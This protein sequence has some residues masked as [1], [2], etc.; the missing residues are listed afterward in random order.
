MTNKLNLTPEQ[1]EARRLLA[2]QMFRQGRSPRAVA[3]A[4]EVARSSAYRWKTAFEKGGFEALKAKKHPGAK[5]R[6]NARQKKRLV[7]ILVDG[8]IKAGYSNDLWTCPRVGQVI[9]RN[10]HVQYHPGHVWHL[11]RNLGWTCQ[12]PEQQAREGD[13]GK[14]ERW[15]R[16]K[17]PQIKRGAAAS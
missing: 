8:P 16:W 3:Q 2:G 15:R 17:W 13:A 9:E 5:P 6:L 12:M 7:K 1:Q 10:F 14:M 4:L 11:L